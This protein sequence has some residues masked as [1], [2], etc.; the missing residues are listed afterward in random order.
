MTYYFFPLT[1][2]E[3]KDP[4]KLGYGYALKNQSRWIASA[5]LG[6][7]NT[8]DRGTTHIVYDGHAYM[9]HKDYVDLESMWVAIVCLVPTRPI[10][11]VQKHICK[12]F[13]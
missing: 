4:N 11:L 6:E 2:E 12:A 1:E 13:L 10:N 8:Y 9:I 3:T 7:V 5:D